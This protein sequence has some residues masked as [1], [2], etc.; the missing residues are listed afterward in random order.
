MDRE[1]T[2]KERAAIRRRRLAPFIA[3]A[4]VILGGIMVLFILMHPSVR[5]G[6]L[7]FATV[8]KGTIQTSVTGTGSVVPA[9]EEII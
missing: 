8:D 2:P 1:L 6:N 3:G 9:F 4:V 7:V 5:R